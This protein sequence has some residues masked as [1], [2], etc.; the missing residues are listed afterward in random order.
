M[1]DALYAM[2][3]VQPHIQPLGIDVTLV[4]F[5][6]AP[7][8]PP[9]RA[10]DRQQRPDMHLAF[11]ARGAVYAEPVKEDIVKRKQRKRRGGGVD[12]R[13]L[14]LR[15]VSASHTG[16]RA[17]Q[18]YA[19]SMRVA[20]Y[21]DPALLTKA[22]QARQNMDKCCKGCQLRCSCAERPTHF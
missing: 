6:L 19:C 7:E 1:V 22:V 21:A 15:K 3:A 9:A 20:H 16:A 18:T 4:Q 13:E 14:Q 11:D 17:R 5:E 8:H 2:C 10:Q 12:R